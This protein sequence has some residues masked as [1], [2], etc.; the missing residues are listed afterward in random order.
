MIHNSVG[1][2]VFSHDAVIRLRRKIVNGDG[3][4][5]ICQTHRYYHSTRYPMQSVLPILTN[6]RSSDRQ[7][8]PQALAE[9]AAIILALNVTSGKQPNQS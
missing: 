5:R 3:R 9:R 8:S 1:K 6:D 4:K 2:S 7:P